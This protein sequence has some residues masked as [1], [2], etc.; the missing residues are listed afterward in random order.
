M[1][2]LSHTMP[3]WW[4]WAAGFWLILVVALGVA[5]IRKTDTPFSARTR[6][7]L[8]LIRA[9]AS[10]ILLVLI[11]NWSVE[12]TRRTD[13]TPMVRV[14][15]DRSASMAATDAPGGASRHAAALDAAKAVAGICPTSATAS[16]AADLDAGNLVDAPRGERSAI[17]QAMFRTLEDSGKQALGGVVILSDFAASDEDA[18]RETVQ[19]YQ[20]AK[21]PVFTRPLGTANQPAD[22][23]LVA[24]HITQP[25]PSQPNL[26]LVATVE[27][28]GYAE[29]DTAIAISCTGQPLL[30]QNLRLTGGRQTVTIDFPSPYRGLNFYEVRLGEIAGE[31]TLANNT[32]RAACELRRD[33]IRVLYMEGSPPNETAF[34]KDALEAD[35]DMEV[36]AMHL[37]SEPAAERDE[38]GR[39]HAASPAERADRGAKLRGKDPRVFRD[40]KGRPVPSVCHPTQGFPVSMEKLLSYDVIILSDIM[41][42]AYSSEQILSMVAF[43]EEFGGG[44]VM[45]GGDTSFGAGGFEKTPIDKLMP[46]EV[47]NKSDPQWTKENFLL[48]AK[49]PNGPLHPIMQVGDTP[50]ESRAA[51]VTRFAGFRGINYVK[52]AKPGAL[53]TARTD[54]TYDPSALAAN[55]TLNDLVLFAVQQIGRGRAMA[56]CS[57]TTTGWGDYFEHFWGPDGRN[58]LYF[59]RFWNNSVRW[60]AADRIARKKGRMQIVL[61]NPQCAPGDTLRITIPAASAGELAQLELSSTEGGAAP[62][63]LPVIWN[64]A[65]RCWEAR[66]TPKAAGETRFEAAYRNAEGG[67]VKLE[68][69]LY[70]TPDANEAVAIAARPDLAA[71]IARDTGGQVLTADNTAKTFGDLSKKSVSTTWMRREPVWDS[72]W[73]LIP[74]LALVMAEWVIRRRASK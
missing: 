58:N 35:Q 68:A 51:W 38:D 12:T 21:V 61:S 17:G 6:T 29:R 74:L 71:E 7:L 34:L 26:R 3:S 57:D 27:S 30:T 59:A 56:F 66:F 39:Q 62:Q 15:V 1:P 33:P 9:A 19:L 64:N 52:R 65:R 4:P 18:I 41:K 37:P 44:F 8:W 32:L 42:E 28:P 46:I 5:F 22:L 54:L 25:G 70:A 53:V 45:V 73:L 31:A 63:L 20:S 24:A 50:S 48:K 23:R 10:A 72:V 49:L 69:G 11:L 60:L 14:L 2:P 47:A 43:V 36:H 67:L 13:E 40:N 16:F 55:P